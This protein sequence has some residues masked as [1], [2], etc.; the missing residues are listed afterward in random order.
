[1]PRP[2]WPVLELGQGKYEPR[3]RS[4]E[5]FKKLLGTCEMDI[6]TSLNGQIRENLS[7]NKSYDNDGL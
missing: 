6:A 2:K 7:I 5:L 1:M 3:N 4:Q